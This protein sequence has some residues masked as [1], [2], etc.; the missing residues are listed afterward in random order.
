VSG[1][2]DETVNADSGL[3]AGL[4]WAFDYE[5]AQKYKGKG[6]KKKNPRHPVQIIEYCSEKNNVY[7]DITS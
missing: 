4:K 1:F 2:G 5:Y 7:E 3:T 6:W